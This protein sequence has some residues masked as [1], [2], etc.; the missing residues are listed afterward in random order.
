MFDSRQYEWADI[1]IIIGG[2]DIVTIR[3]VKWTR[4]IERESV[5]GKGRYAHSIQTGNESNE[6]EFTMLQSDFDAIELA[7]GGDILSANVDCLIVFGDPLNGDKMTTHRVIGAR[8]TEDALE[9]KQGD[10]FA[11]VK[12]PWIAR[13]IQKNV[14]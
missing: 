5:Y 4:K 7:A 3:G 12:L 6:G 11:E 2:R 10:K 14:T 13:R 9:M 1:T 8:F